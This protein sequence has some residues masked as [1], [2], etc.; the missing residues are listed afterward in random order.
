MPFIYG[1]KISS[2]GG[3]SGTPGT[4]ENAQTAQKLARARTIA[5]SGDATGSTEFD[6]SKNVEISTSVNAITNTE[7]EE[8]LK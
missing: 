3:S 5:L 8:I 7:L 6:G 1:G 4:S 2:S